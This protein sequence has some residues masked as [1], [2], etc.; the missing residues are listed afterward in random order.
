MPQWLAPVITVIC[1]IAASGGFWAMLQKRADKKDAKSKMIL[2]LG[3]D[4]ILYLCMRYIEQGFITK[5]E[6]ENLHRY[7]YAP[8]L[9]MGGNGTVARLMRVVDSLPVRKSIPKPEKEDT[10]E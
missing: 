9:E 10:D 5:D 2:G 1:S 3:H 8:Y 4:R 6:L 7:L